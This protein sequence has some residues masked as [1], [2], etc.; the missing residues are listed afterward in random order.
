MIR[1]HVF[2][3]LFE[4]T[5]LDSDDLISLLTDQLYKYS[6]CL[7]LEFSNQSIGH[8]NLMFRIGLVTVLTSV[9]R[10]TFWINFLFAVRTPNKVSLSVLIVDNAHYVAAD[11]KVLSRALTVHK[12]VILVDGV[13]HFRNEPVVVLVTS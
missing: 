7:I 12:S 13:H 2:L 1:R 6:I 11:L 10:V 5:G 8:S 3:H 4:V 9:V